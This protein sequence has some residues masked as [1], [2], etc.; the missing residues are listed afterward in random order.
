MDLRRIYR[1][2]EIVDAHNWWKPIC[3]KKEKCD[4]LYVQ[5]YHNLFKLYC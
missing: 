2:C 1:M 5:S 4:L 3:V